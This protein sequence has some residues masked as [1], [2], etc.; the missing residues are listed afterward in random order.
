MSVEK[1]LEETIV[2]YSFNSF[3]KMCM[4]RMAFYFITLKMP[5]YE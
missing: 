5:L 3:E 4:L 2:V 1:L